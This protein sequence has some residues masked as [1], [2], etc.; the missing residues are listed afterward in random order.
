[1]EPVM[2]DPLDIIDSY[3]AV[4]NESD[5]EVR[6]QR[7]RE[8]WTPDG[9]TCYRLLD[10]QGYAAI[11]ERVRGSW[12]RWVGDGKFVFRRKSAVCHHDAIKFEF[13]AAAVTDGRVE[14]D[15]LCLLI[16][17]PDGRIEHDY[18]FNPTADEES[19]VVDRY[20]AVLNE[21]DQVVRRDLVA[22][23]WAPEGALVTGSGIRSG[24]GAIE[25]AAAEVHAARAAAAFSSANA[26]HA[27]HDLVKFKWRL[28]SSKNG[29]P[30]AATEFLILDVA[31][32]IR[33]DYRFD[34]GG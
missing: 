18:Q 9:S 6:R 13:V 23:L 11:E 29:R 2:A 26:T 31:G 5:L 10:A 27:H 32:R 8:V 33:R 34:E 15:G 4:W 14:A 19:R 30:L 1:M 21:A 28:A 16:L 25:A 7:I 17:A 12:E 22:E 24:R 20:L 3:V